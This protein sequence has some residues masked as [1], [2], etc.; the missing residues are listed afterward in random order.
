M[1]ASRVA[2]PFEPSDS[3]LTPGQAMP[4]RRIGAQCCMR[5]PGSQTKIDVSEGTGWVSVCHGRG[6]M[7]KCL[8]G[9]GF[10]SR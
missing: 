3:K 9:D 4:A 5:S 10:C 1:L 2:D 7:K 6:G 8:F